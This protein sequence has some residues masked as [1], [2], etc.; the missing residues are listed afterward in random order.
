MTNTAELAIQ[1]DT[2]THF[3]E[4]QSDAAADRYVFAYTITIR[5]NSDQP[6]QLK[7]RYWLITDSNGKKTEVSGDGVIGQ[8]PS[9][10]PGG[11]FVYTSGAVVETPVATMQGYYNM[12][13]LADQSSFETQIPVFRLAQ[14][15]ILN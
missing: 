14:P 7:S 8:Q 6:V 4:E 12:I 10:K 11:K 5:N 13:N 2:E 3:V 9:I 1:V 15:N